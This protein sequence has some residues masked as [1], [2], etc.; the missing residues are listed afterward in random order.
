MAGSGEKLKTELRVR[1]LLFEID[2]AIKGT[3]VL[4]DQSCYN[5]FIASADRG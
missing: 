1:T 5:I 2:V 4:E 3:R